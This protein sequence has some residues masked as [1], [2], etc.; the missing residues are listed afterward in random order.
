M[1]H[2][3]KEHRFYKNKTTLTVYLVLRALIIFILFPMRTI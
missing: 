3:L 2:E 1:S